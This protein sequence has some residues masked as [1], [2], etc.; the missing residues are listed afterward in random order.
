MSDKRS[1]YFPQSRNMHTQVFLVI[2]I[3]EGEIYSWHRKWTDGFDSHESVS[4]IA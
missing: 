2:V 1:L 4:V 3:D